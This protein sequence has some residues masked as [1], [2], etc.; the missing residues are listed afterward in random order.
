MSTRG[1]G[2][3][4]TKGKEY[5]RRKMEA[6]VNERC[7]NAWRLSKSIGWTGQTRDEP[8]MFHQKAMP[9]RSMMHRTT[10]QALKKAFLQEKIYGVVRNKRLYLCMA[11]Y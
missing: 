5:T 3:F 2:R 6:K 11:H 10:T 8:T 7:L 1:E 9:C 4:E